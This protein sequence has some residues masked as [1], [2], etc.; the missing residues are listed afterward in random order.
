MKCALY[1]YR[2]ISRSLHAT[3]PVWSVIE[4]LVLNKQLKMCTIELPMHE[5]FS[6][7]GKAQVRLIASCIMM[8]LQITTC[9][10]IKRCNSIL[11]LITFNLFYT[12]RDSQ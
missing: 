11:V 7:F 12:F 10:F 3:V 4:W 8:T 5:P 2:K 9:I 6:S 1:G